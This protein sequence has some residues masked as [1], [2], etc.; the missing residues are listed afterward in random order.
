MLR[1]ILLAVSALIYIQSRACNNSSFNIVSQTT[2]P[3][4]SIT[5]VLNLT[6]ELGGFDATFYGFALS[7]NS[8]FNTPTVTAFDPSL[9][10]ADLTSGNLTETLFGQTGGSINSVAGD[11]DWNQYAGMTNVLSYEDGSLFGAASNDISLTLSVTVMGC[12]ETIEFNA[13]VNSGSA[14]CLFTAPTGQNCASCSITALALG[15]QTACNPATNTYTQ[16]VIVTY[17]NPPGA[18]TLDVNGQSFAITGSPQTVTLTGLTADGNGVNTTAVFS[19]DATCTFTTN[20]LFTAPADCTP[21]PVCSISGLALGTQTACNPATN[22]YTQEVIVTYA[23][24]PGSGTL[25]VNGQSFPITGSPQTVT[26]TGLT[27]DGNGVITTAVFSADA[28]CTFTTNNLFTAPADCTPVPVCSI[29]ALALGTQTACNPATN[30][31]TQEVIVTYTNE[32]GSGTLDVN[33]QSFAITG[34]PQTVTLTGLTADGNGVNTT[35]VF[36][37]D[38]ACT[39]TTNNLFTAP[40]DCTPVPVCSISGLALGTQTACNPATNTYTQEVIVT[41]ANEPGS[42]TLDV[43]GQSFAITGSPQTVTLTGLT[44][45][46]N[47]VNTTAVFSADGACTSTTNNL[48]TAPVACSACAANAG[49]ISK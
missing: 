36:S 45:D 10:N 26:L 32:P 23:N 2:N 7:F 49:T 25:D 31:Y 20:N 14:A 39:F 40:A 6:T 17:T 42:G 34:S 15:T 9:N 37:A 29:S 4:G 46:G 28:T 35:A 13:S 8:P 24:E 33:G 3:D 11:N 19:A 30:T 5:Y 44:A 21:V 48:F 41:Y 12:V 43:N 16:E 47:G 18:G 22:T 38:G 1:F 27:A